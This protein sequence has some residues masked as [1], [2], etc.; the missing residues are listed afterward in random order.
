MTPEEIAVAFF[1]SE[2]ALWLTAGSNHTE[3][4]IGDLRKSVDAYRE[5]GGKIYGER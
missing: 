5:A 4:W 1:K 2:A 3:M